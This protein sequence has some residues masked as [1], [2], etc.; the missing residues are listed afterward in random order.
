MDKLGVQNRKTN[1]ERKGKGVLSGIKTSICSLKDDLQS[2]NK[3]LIFD[4]L[5]FSIGFLLARCQIILGARPLGLVIVALAQGSIWPILTGG[6]IGSLSLGFDGIIFAVATLAVAMIRA[7]V[8]SGDKDEKGEMRLFGEALI[9]RISISVLGGFIVAVYE[10]L[11]HGLNEATLLYGLVMILITPLLTFALSGLVCTGID[12][13]DLLRGQSDILKSNGCDKNEKYNKIFFQASALA[14]IFFVSL[15]IKEINILGI[16]FSYIFSGSITLLVAKRFGAIRA[17]GVGFVSS[18]VLSGTLS[19]AF[20]LAGL[21]SGVMFGFGM[22]YAVIAGGIALC[23]WGAYSS[24]L[25]GLLSTLPEYTIASALVMPLLRGVDEV[26][27][28]KETVT[29]QP[30]SAED[31]VGTMALAYQN[32]YSGSLDSLESALADIS[33]IITNYNKTPTEISLDEYKDIVIS[34]AELSCSGCEEES[35]CAKEDIRPVIKSSDTIARLLYEGKKIRGEDLNS[36]TE[37]CQLSETIA[38]EINREVGRRKQELYLIN[39][40]VEVAEEY[41]LISKLI[42]QARSCDEAERRIDNSMTAALTEAFESCGFK[43]GI[44]RAFGNRRKHFILAGEDESGAKISSFELRK[45]V[46]KA[47]GV[48]LG[49]PEYFRRGRMVLMECGIRRTLKVSIAS[50]TLAGRKNEISGD[51]VSCFESDDDYFYSLI[52]DGMGSGELAKQTSGFVGEYIKGAMKLGA[53]KETLL[54]ILNR[55]IRARREECSATVDL[56]ELDLLNGN[57]I[58]LKSGAAPSYI[59]RESSIF[60]IRSQTTPIG[61]LKSIDTEKISVE[62]KPGDHIIMISDGIADITEDAPWLLLLLSETPRSNLKEYADLILD[63]AR[64][65]S[66]SKDDMSVTVIRVDET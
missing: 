29:E 42:N 23:V 63:E 4:L 48:K 57:G 12:Y 25:S 15:S 8:S 54:H 55:T 53:A 26:T 51:T 22:G 11:V 65:N 33:Q 16:S 30:E 19:V 39:S 6:V 35:L 66:N 24:G 7:A 49:T 62:I 2:K 14:L 47:A 21:C 41:E 40:S 45:S 9:V 28:T 38:E 5:V 32:R 60:R 56:F 43:S 59:K 3:T 58:F 1:R 36:D 44:I 27:Q 52:S 50:S 17:A 37:F 10:A 20:A 18:L 46:E 31:M 13:R 64:K 34:V 61:L